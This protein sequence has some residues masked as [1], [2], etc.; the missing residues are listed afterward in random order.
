V[1]SW[2]Q[3]GLERVDTVAQL[4]F[5]TCKETEVKPDRKHWYENVPKS[6]E[7]SHEGKVTYYR[8]NKCK[9][10]EPSLAINRTS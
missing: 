5:T 8:T 6:V 9:P 4:L 2:D 10:T 3:R 7:S 1:R